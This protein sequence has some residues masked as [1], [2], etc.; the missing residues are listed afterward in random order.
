MMIRC[1]HGSICKSLVA[2]LVLSLPSISTAQDSVQEELVPVDAFV[3][4]ASGLSTSLREV[5]YGIQVPYGFEQLMREDTPAGRY[6]RRAAGLWAVFP[7]SE[8]LP[9]G[10]GYI[11]TWPA[12]TRFHIGPPRRSES[13]S[14]VPPDLHENQ[15][16]EDAGEA[17]IAAEVAEAV[18]IEAE[19]SD[20]RT[21]VA[22]PSTVETE[23]EAVRPSPPPRIELV[24][25]PFVVDSR[26][27][28]SRIKAIVEQATRDSAQAARGPSP[29]SSK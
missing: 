9:T 23:G 8:Y 19:A 18:L 7:R 1:I 28:S 25:V 24:R 13:M 21:I 22:S 29:S 17:P 2:G 26:Y 6:V 10:S 15:I 27:R 3:E 11:A 4:D 14:I 16:L 12:D 20:G 5:Q